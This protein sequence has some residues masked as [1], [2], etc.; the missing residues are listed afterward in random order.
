MGKKSSLES[1]WHGGCPSQK[2]LVGREQLE[3]VQIGSLL[4]RPVPLTMIDTS[5]SLAR[6]LCQILHLKP[7]ESH[8]TSTRSVGRVSFLCVC[9]C[10]WVCVFLSLSLSLSRSLSLCVCVCAC[11]CVSLSL[12]LSLTQISYLVLHFF[13]FA[14]HSVYLRACV[15]MCVFVCVVYKYVKFMKIG[16]PLVE[17]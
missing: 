4:G 5:L 11:V 9:V 13:K 3:V 16:P 2:L 17:L 7:S 1:D 10:V 14:H 6:F 12:S 15:C 8:T